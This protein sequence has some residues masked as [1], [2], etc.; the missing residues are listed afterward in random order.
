LL[1]GCVCH[2]TDAGDA[3]TSGLMQK[4]KKAKIQESGNIKEENTVLSL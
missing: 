3:K 2:L 1:E 4:K